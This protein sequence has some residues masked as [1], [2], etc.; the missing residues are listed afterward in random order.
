MKKNFVSLAISLGCAAMAFAQTAPAQTASNAAPPPSTP[1]GVNA[2]LPTK[3]AVINV[4]Q[5]IYQTKEGSSAAASVTA[6][7]QP[8][9]EEFEKRQRDM[10]NI[11]DQLKKGSATMSDDAKQKLERDLDGKQKSLQRD[12]QE[13]SDDY[14]QEMGK[15]FQ[16]IGNKM[17]KSAIE[18]YCYQNGYAVVIDVSN[19]QT[20]VIWMAPSADITADII[21]L[22][23]QAHPATGA[24]AA[25]KPATLP[26]PQTPP[27]IKK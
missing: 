27:V 15:I 10:Q 4:Q 3:V 11:S 1:S 2:S 6:K 21:K 8:K 14:E 16:E 18:P 17:L 9:K 7:Y 12:T 24:P 22:Y 26:K 20:P 25:A 5:A 19:Q 13:T 23:D